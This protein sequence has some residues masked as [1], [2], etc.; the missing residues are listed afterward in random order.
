MFIYSV[1]DK[2]GNFFTSQFFAKN[3][4]E[5]VRSVARVANDSRSDLSMFPYDFALYCDGEFDSN[6]GLVSGFNPLKHVVD[7]DSLIKI[8][9]KGQ[10]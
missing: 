4:A 8:E 3:D 1:F 6:N 2:K 7:V 5:A 9:T 10:A